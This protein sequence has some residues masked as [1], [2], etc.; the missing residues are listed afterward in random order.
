LISESARGEGGHLLNGNGERFV[1]ELLPRDVVA[2]SIY[3]QISKGQEVF[4]DIRSLGE[5]KLMEL[6]PQE[7]HLCRLHEGVDPLT[8]LIP[9]KPVAHYSM[10]GIDVDRELNV[11]NIQG[12]FAVGE[13]SNAKVHGANRLGGNSLLEIISFGKLV[14][15]S[16][17]EYISNVGEIDVDEKQLDR[18]RAYISELYSRDSSINFYK[19]RDEVGKLFYESVGIVR[20]E[21]RLDNALQKLRKIKRDLPLMGIDDRYQSYNRNLIEFLEFI[22]MVEL[23]EVI[24]LSAIKRCESRGAHYRSDYPHQDDKNFAL[25]TLSRKIDQEI[26]I[27]FVKS[28][29]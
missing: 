17:Y 3:E 18:D 25:H 6:L 28:Y 11:H 23:G 9:I 20:D 8:E 7:V 19:K 5:E 13:T 15:D 16:A 29:V 27:S 24:L 14:V 2:R 10:G 12:C 4:L 1:D 26:E 21:S 22:N